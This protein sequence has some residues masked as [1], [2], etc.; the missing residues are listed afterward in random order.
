MLKKID[1]DAL[2]H[3]LMNSFLKFGKALLACVTASRERKDQAVNTISIGGVL[4]IVVVK[5]ANQQS[6]LKIVETWK[7][8]IPLFK[9]FWKGPGTVANVAELLLKML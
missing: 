3:I 6:T 2:S 1:G 7:G 5:L 4:E 8:V 9:T